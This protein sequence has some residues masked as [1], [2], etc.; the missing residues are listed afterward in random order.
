MKVEALD[1]NDLR[2]LTETTLSNR[3]WEREG[4]RER[5]HPRGAREGRALAPEEVNS[6]EANRLM[7]FFTSSL[8]TADRLLP[9][10]CPGAVA[11]ICSKYLPPGSGLRCLSVERVWD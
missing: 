6:S 3:D 9:W 10:C 4:F 8:A 1:P 7:G 2:A 5:R 11:P